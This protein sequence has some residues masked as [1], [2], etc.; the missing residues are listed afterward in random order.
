MSSSPLFQSLSSDLVEIGRR[1]DACGWV[2]GTS[3][4]FSGVAS[5][6]PLRLAVT[7]SGAPKGMMKPEEILEIDATAEPVNGDSR[8]PSAEALLHVRIVQRKQAGAVLHTHSTW[9]TM[10]SDL[11]ALQGGLAIEG[12]EM[13]KGLDGVTSHEHR[14][15][16]PIV[17]NDQDMGR[18]WADMA[19]ALDEC[20]DAHGVLIR[21]HG[22]YTWG[23]SL[24]QALRHVEI[25][26]FLL[27]TV[28]QTRVA[29]GMMPVDLE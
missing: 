20:P 17:E 9:S 11:D 18:L 29:R 6:D 23:E 28:G 10:L 15:W 13:L 19:R 1:F 26:E 21:R 8:R 22:L 12:Y 3:G 24:E 25:L 2:R 5:R 14:E 4:N 27:E 16:L 7:P